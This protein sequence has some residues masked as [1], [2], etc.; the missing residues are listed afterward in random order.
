MRISASTCATFCL[1]TVCSATAAGLVGGAFAAFTTPILAQNRNNPEK[2]NKIPV[3]F[4]VITLCAAV[5]SAG[6]GV[7]A[8]EVAR[9]AIKEIGV[10]R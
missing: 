5:V 4:A 6:V 7:V 9:A 2:Q 1:A 10:Q 8:A 3:S